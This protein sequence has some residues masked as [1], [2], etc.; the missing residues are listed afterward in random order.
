[1]FPW[2]QA[3][4]GELPGPACDSLPG[5]SVPPFVRTKPAPLPEPHEPVLQSWP[6]PICHVC[7]RHERRVSECERGA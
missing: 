3:A 2:A 1:M 4:P 7:P 6:V 5:E